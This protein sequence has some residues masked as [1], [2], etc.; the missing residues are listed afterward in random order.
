MPQKFTQNMLY[1][2]IYFNEMKLSRCTKRNV[3]S[4][5]GWIPTVPDE[6]YS[7]NPE[8]ITLMYAA[9]QSFGTLY[10]EIV[11]GSV[12]GETCLIFIKEMMPAY[13]RK[14]LASRNRAFIMDNAPI[15]HHRGP[16]ND[17]M[18]GIVVAE[19]IGLD[20]LELVCTARC[21]CIKSSA[22]SS[23]FGAYKF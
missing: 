21:F 11:E 4:I 15:H 8:L 13:M 2:A 9:S 7:T 23:A 19:T 3:W 17:Y 5:K 14:G 20:Y 12:P 10:F 18:R 1:N 6:P 16:V 22:F